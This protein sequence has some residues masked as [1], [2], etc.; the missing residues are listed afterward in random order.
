[1]QI[2]LKD[3]VPQLKK[4]AEDTKLKM[5]VV[6]KEKA[7]ADVL[8]ES[9]SLEEATVQLAVDKANAIK[10]D[11]EKDLNEALPALEAAEN[12]LNVISKSQIDNLKTMKQ[13][14]EPIK[15]T[16]KVFIFL[17]RVDFK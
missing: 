15:A 12:A 10:E 6:A 1:M 16:M 4:A 9:I 7:S 5:E 8:A 2:Q 3:M 13:P 17:F 11:C 14:A